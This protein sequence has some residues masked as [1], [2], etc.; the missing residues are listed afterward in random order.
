[1]KFSQRLKELRKE[2]GMTQDD[3]GKQI[4]KT[5]ST[6]AGYETE[7]KEPDYATLL[8]IAEYFHVTTDYLLGKTQDKQFYGREVLKI[9]K[10]CEKGQEY[11]NIHHYTSQYQITKKEIEEVLLLALEIY[12]K[13]KKQN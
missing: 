7:R 5:R 4:S 10:V 3:L 11:L 13:G 9:D 2:K 8:S 12:K 1:M 6:I